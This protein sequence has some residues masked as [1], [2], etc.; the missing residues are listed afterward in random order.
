MKIYGRLALLIG[1]G[2]SLLC[3]AFLYA[4]DSGYDLF[5][6][7][8][9]KERTEADLRGA[10]KLYERV[11]KE[12]AN[13]RKLAA[14]ALFRI[15]ECQQGLGSAEARKAFERVVKEFADQTE[16][17]AQAQAR[18][19]GSGASGPEKTVRRVWTGPDVPELGKISP[20]GR[21]LAFRQ[22]SDLFVRDFASKQTRL[23]THLPDASGSPAWS[24]DGRR[25]AYHA[26]RQQQINV[27]N[28]DG[29]GMRTIYRNAD[30]LGAVVEAW[31]PDSKRL[32]V[33]AYTKPDGYA[34]F[35]W[36][37]VADGA[38]QP[39]PARAFSWGGNVFPSPDGKYVVF[40]GMPSK[41]STSD[42]PYIIG[43]DGT[44]ESVL[45][46]SNMPH[47]D[48]VTWTPDGRYILSTQY[49]G[50]SARG[51]WAIPMAGGK[52]QGQPLRI[53]DDFGKDPLR[54][55]GVGGGAFYY[56]ILTGASDI[57]TVSM[58]RATGKVTSSPI[59]VPTP[60]NGAVLPRWSPDSQ[61]LL[62]E[63]ASPVG[64]TAWSTRE[65]W[66]YSFAADKNQR[67]AS[68]VPL[69]TGGS[70][71][72]RDA[73][74]L[75]FNRGAD[76][77]RIESV[78]FNLSKG[79]AEPLFQGASSFILRSCS[80]EL[81]AGYD[82]SGI[83]VRN[84]QNGSEKQIYTFPRTDGAPPVRLPVLS[85]DG[86]SVAVISKMDGDSS[87][88]LVIPSDGGAPRE[89]T[90]AKSPIELQPL[91][92]VAWAPDDRFVYFARRPDNKTPYELFRIPAQGGA[93]ESTGLKVPDIRDLDISPDGTRIAF[94][95][96]AVAQPEIWAME[97]FLPGR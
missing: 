44:G 92:G 42:A 14:Q 15:G 47:S 79:Q 21:L 61:R 52:V 66:I 31:A 13:D 51:L 60:R 86:R 3:A 54:I 8:L 73:Q 25:L 46:A 57:Y 9:A 23:V 16:V 33:T 19:A 85:H 76:Q 41:D 87:A 68:G 63:T 88:L 91:W 59:F 67:V 34:R 48:A 89:L 69:A 84:L 53:Q 39:I 97:N 5:Q 32:L 55:I 78:R 72:S 7:G 37:N 43:S 1:L 38:V 20:D 96:G 83:K 95:I 64:A 80:D 6:K 49:Q 77:E 90:R 93:E 24:P 28:L 71:W 26:A 11:V 82:R 50:G 74:T 17:V 81:V 62:Y 94:S 12:H 30:D 58:A 56:S 75:L 4:A 45:L 10:I 65:L 18:L 29:S 40:P 22:N 27:I 2:V 36:L 35:L 70:C